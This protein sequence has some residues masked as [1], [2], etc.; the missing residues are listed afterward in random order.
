MTEIIFVKT[1]PASLL[2]TGSGITTINL[3]NFDNMVINSKKS[4]VKVQRPKTK[5]SQNS[6]TTDE[7]DNQV[8]DLKKLEQVIHFSGWLE[9]DSSETAWNKLWKLIAMQTRGG[10]LTSLTIGTSVP[11]VFPNATP[12]VYPTTTPQAFVE[13]VTGN[14]TSD[15]TGDI[16]ASHSA[17]PARIKVDLDIYLGYER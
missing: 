1:L 6:T 3:K 2:Y 8:I 12:A 4:L 13:T 7:A 16:T 14:I 5:T 15:D 9:D 10:A 17:K 11:Q